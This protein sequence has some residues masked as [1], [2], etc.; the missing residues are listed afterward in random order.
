MTIDTLL[1]PLEVMLIE[2][3]RQEGRQEGRQE[4]KVEA[5]RAALTD[6]LEVRF[7]GE[8]VEAFGLAQALSDEGA[9]RRAHR[10]AITSPDLRAFLDAIAAEK[11]P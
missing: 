10:L 6:A 11:K 5:L 8:A 4:A 2:E 9:L 3:S 1:S 7:G